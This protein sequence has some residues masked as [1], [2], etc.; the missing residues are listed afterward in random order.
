MQGTLAVQHFLLCR[1]G[2]S[3]R[4]IPIQA[5]YPTAFRLNLCTMLQAGRSRVRFLRSLDF[6]IG[7]ILRDVLCA[8]VHSAPDP[9]G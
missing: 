9:H 3:V 4:P 1:L 5:S 8:E 7:L 2:P 6:S